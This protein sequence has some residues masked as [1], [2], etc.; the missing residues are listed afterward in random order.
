[1]PFAL[2]FT[3]EAM[4]VLRD[5]ETDPAYAARLAKVRKCLALLEQNPRHPGLNTHRYRSLHGPNGED[6][7]EIYVENRTPSA[8][9]IWYWYG[10]GRGTI[11]I[12]TIGPHP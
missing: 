4:G 6:V 9:R 3:T 10:P 12:L 1:V 7:W 2:R 5:M 11:T 8:W